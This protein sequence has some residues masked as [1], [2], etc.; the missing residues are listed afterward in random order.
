MSI[1]P[2]VVVEAPDGRGL[3]RVTVNGADAGSA[4]SL[5]ELRALLDRLGHPGVDVEDPASVHWR[6]GDSTTWPDRPVG[7]RLT[8]LIVLA[9]L[10]ASAVLNAVIGWPDAS[11][12][13]TFAQRVTGALFVLSA[14]VLV[15]A[16]LSVPDHWG[17]RRS[18]VSG[19]L[20]LLGVLITLA[21]DVLL[22]LLWLDER[23]YTP[24]LL[25][26]MPL[27][28]W[29]AWALR[30]LLKDRP[31]RGMPLPRTFATGVFASAL[32]TAV[33]L[34]YSTL[35]QPTVAPMHFAL[36]ARFGTARADPR[37]PFVQVPLTMSVKNTGAYPAYVLID[38]YTVYGRTARYTDQGSF[39]AEQWRKSIDED[40]E[41]EAERHVDRLAFTR[42]SSGRIYEPGTLLES[43]QEDTR[44]H[45]FQIPLDAP[46]DLLYVDLQLTYLRKDRGQIDV[47]EFRKQRAS[48]RAK[49]E[50]PCIA[51]GCGDRIVYLGAVR[52]NNNLVNVTRAQHYVLATWSPLDTPAYS[53]SSY[54]L[55]GKGID[56]A[57]EKKDLARFG[58][59]TVQA[60]AE[61]S[62]AELLKSVTA[63]RPS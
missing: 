52:H 9:G 36:S 25:A 24:Y 56:L 57:E 33:S 34:A 21:T 32:L 44:E 27:L 23:Q 54:H 11:G 49:N 51:G 5:R 8:G 13:L 14:L 18:S 20:V 53:I 26:F 59:S 30:L 47:E 63:P 16:A 3:R 2:W 28:C 38:D 58:V 37:V 39:S 1:R 15:A 61:I 50:P 46:Y 43:G 7:R 4:W 29:S 35:Y 12:A 22:V 41:E 40:G 60:H 19:A 48:W 6:G 55:D 31:W 17:R 10:L 62:L 45:V 42:I